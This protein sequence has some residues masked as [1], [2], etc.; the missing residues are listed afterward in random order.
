[1]FRLK[2]LVTRIV[3]LSLLFLI[4]GRLLPGRGLPDAVALAGSDIFVNSGQSLGGETGN[5]VALGDLNGNGYLD[6]FVANNY[7]S[8]GPE[9]NQVWF[10][11]GNGYFTAGPTLGNFDGYAVALGDLDGDGDLDAVVGGS[12]GNIVWINQGGAQGGQPGTFVSGAM[13]GAAGYGIT[14]GDVDNDGDLDALVVGN[15]NQL[16]LNNGNATFNAGPAFPV[17]SR[18]A[19]L[20]DLDGDGWLDAL[21]ADSA[22]GPANQVWWND[23]NWNP[24]P[25]SF[26]PGPLLPMENLVNGVAVA[27]LDGDGRLDIFLASAGPNQ[28]FWNEGERTFSTAGPLPVND[29]SSAVALA[30]VDGDGLV[31]AVV[32]NTSAQPN[33]LWR[34][35]GGRVFTV[36]Q[37]FGNESG[38]YWSRGLGL[39]DLNGDGSAD[40]FEVTTAEDRVWFN[41][42]TPPPP[43]PNL[44]GWQIQLLA[45]R[46]DTG[47]LPALALDGDGYP[48]ISYVSSHVNGYDQQAG[49]YTYIFRLNYTRWEGVSWHTEAVRSFLEGVESVSLALDG[50]GYPH[51]AYAPGFG[52]YPRYA[53]WDGVRWQDEAFPEFTSP[54]VDVEHVSLALDAGGAPHVSYTW[55]NFDTQNW[56][57]NYTFWDGVAWQVET[58][59]VG[60]AVFASS[61]ALDGGGN[62]HVIYNVRLANSDSDDLK[63]A[64]KSGGA[65]QPENVDVQVRRFNALALDNA[66]RPHVAYYTYGPY[67]PSLKHA[68]RDGNDWQVQIIVDSGPD[69]EGV[70]L[71]LDS[72]QNPHL[73]YLTT[74]IITG[75]FF[76]YA[77]W[78]GAEWQIE[79]LD[80]SSS[81]DLPRMSG[82]VRLALDESNNVHAA[83]YE[84]RFS[85][86]RYLTWAPNWQIRA[87]PESGTIRTPSLDLSERPVGGSI[88]P[89]L[90]YYNQTSGQIK[91]ASWERA[92][93]MN[94]VTFVANPVTTLS[95]AAG[96]TTEHVTYYDADNQ[97]LIYSYWDGS[98]WRP[99]IVDEAGNVGRYNSLVL[100]GTPRIAYWD[101]TSRRVKLAIPAA[102][103]P[104]W[105]IYPNNAG[106]T[107]N[108]ASGPLSATIL[109]GGDHGIAYYDGANGDLRLAVWHRK[110]ESWTDE[111]VD[112]ATADVGHLNSLQTDGTEG[113]PVLAYLDE[114]Q[115]AIKFAYKAGGVWQTQVAVPG[116]PGETVTALSLT[117]GLN[118]RSRAR[119]AYTTV[120]GAL[121]VAVLR[122]GAWQIETVVSGE[123]SAL[124]AVSA[125]LDIRPHLA[126]TPAGG[127]L[128]YA[129]RT[130][131]L[132]ADTS[133]PGTPPPAWFTSGGYYNPLDACQA[134]LD[135]ISGDSNRSDS[136][137]STRKALQG[138]TASLGDLAIF[139]T[140]TEL[141]DAIPGGQYYIDLYRQHGSEMGQLGL[142]DPLLLWDAYGTLQNFLPGLE[143]L[144]TGQGDQFVVTQ[145]MVN[146]ALDIWQRLAAA[147]TP[148]LAAMINNELAKYDDLQ[149]FVGLTFN[150]WAVAI[151][152]NPTVGRVYL[153]VVVR[154]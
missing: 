120:T 63:Y 67:P 117:L 5:G 89:Y 36:A 104:L 105:N 57:L 74:S 145:E 112:G 129:F 96:S 151:G 142:D 58:I 25:G 153:P 47:L 144:V 148:E 16:W 28:L 69:A 122:D 11:D 126:Y 143:G 121:R 61:L 1:M 29:N 64:R 4:A 12:E 81:K 109:P 13:L 66:G 138:I 53:H 115:G 73:F 146:D 110:S 3:M 79:T 65:W 70:S 23:G 19:V 33:R 37:E 147:G 83:Y 40:L 137:F 34:N 15:S 75:T 30:D 21:I 102:E 2:T 131:A 123:G 72:S 38:L 124:T 85:D 51:I 42:A 119:I 7:S 149:D 139:G 101:A 9:A 97:R 8:I 84:P 134:I 82:G 22:S 106:P 99:E 93:L 41:Q 76:E 130:A 141:F 50:N 150:E 114:T 10:N 95:L 60:Q 87:L 44:E 90:G 6:A 52:Q 94:P 113:V 107:L 91:V 127:G 132:D 68:Y 24:G 154:P 17:F 26:T 128:Q 140:M 56:Q 43:L 103:A 92:W 88:T 118:S 135:L 48:H 136:S 55:Y 54:N 80:Y 86:L 133:E 77:R 98:Q 39:G 27:D 20:A 31:D 45:S 32:G 14:L 71:A 116:Q 62:P 78:D 18:A 108:E 49:T 59:D 111:R 100:A 46:G 35:E 152:V 125:A